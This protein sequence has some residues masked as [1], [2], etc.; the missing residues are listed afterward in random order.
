MTIG[1]T[2]LQFPNSILIDEGA[3]TGGIYGR[4]YKSG[5]TDP[6]GAPIGIIAEIGFGPSG[7]DPTSSSGWQWTGATFN[8]QFGNEMSLPQN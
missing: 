4:V 5:V 6:A 1:Y 8:T 2:V 7:S 3:S